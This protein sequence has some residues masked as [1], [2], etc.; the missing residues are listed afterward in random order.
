MKIA[1]IAG[2]NSRNSGGLYNSVRNLGQ[3]MMKIDGLDPVI[4]AYSDEHSAQDI[5]AYSPLPLEDYKLIGSNSFAL[6]SDINKKLQQIKPDIIHP[7]CIWIY[8][9]F[10]TL[11]Y[12]KQ[13]NVPYIIS[14]R[15]MLDKWILNNNAWKKKLVGGLY[16]REYIKNANCLNALALSEYEAMRDF[17]CKNPIAI[18]PNGVNLPSEEWPSDAKIPTWRCND[19]RKVML[20][21][22]RLHPKKGIE[23]MIKAWAGLGAYKKEWKL[24]IAGESKDEIYMQ[25]LN[26]AIKNSNLNN[27]VFLVGPQFNFDKDICFRC[28][29]AFIL[30]SF[31][32]GLPMA[33]L[34]AWSYGLPVIMTDACNIPEGFE[35]NAAL[36]IS[37]DPD[38]ILSELNRLFTMPD[39]ERIDMGKRG[40]QL[41]KDKFTWES[42][43]RQTYSVY[44]WI[45]NGGKMPS[46]I[47]TF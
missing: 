20:F 15:G 44:Q 33:V 45:L 17:G 47:K 8:P 34:E 30:P 5:K 32:E 35:S 4:L 13:N 24:I 36:Q 2:S 18:I 37:P 42:I 25:T 26:S 31:S 27:D 19:D 6:S 9:S 46:V 22:S 1:L 3:S 16:E 11:R 41:V 7:Q 43:A 23:N 21:L 39:S 14:T 40:K 29:D 38:S 12:H 10:A 28:S